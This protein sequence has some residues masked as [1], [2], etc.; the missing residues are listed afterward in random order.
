MNYWKQTKNNIYVAAHRGWKT[1]YPENTIPAFRA[2][3]ELGVDQL[4]C[5]VRVTLDG[6]LVVIHDAT[7]D[8]TTNGRG[9]VAEKTFA[10]LRAL[11][12][13]CYMGEEFRGERIPTF[14]ELMELV[15]DHPTITLDVELKEYPD[16]PGNETRALEVCDR[17]LAMID[18]Y[19]FTDRV[20]IN[21]W[22]N[23]LNEYIFKTYGKKYRQHVYYPLPVMKGKPTLDPYS[24]A[25][26]TCMF[27]AI[28]SEIN[29]A[30]KCEFD[31]MAE[32]GPEPWAGAGVADEAGVDRAIACGATLITCNNPDVI[33][34]LLRKKGYHS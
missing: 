12:A 33:L 10:E 6:E 15:R 30:E 28:F 25:Y 26:C 21:T 20:V 8:R 29:I 17:V 34:E 11:D 27:R 18:E 24:Y 14:R 13:G 9:L 4:E 2:A 31:R 19:G 7:V 5:D 23:P 16:Q 3:M 32:M 1:K 22:S